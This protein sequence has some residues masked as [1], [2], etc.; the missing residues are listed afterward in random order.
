MNGTSIIKSG[1]V[2]QRPNANTAVLNTKHPS[3]KEKKLLKE[4]NK[5]ISPSTVEAPA[6]IIY[7][8]IT[9]RHHVLSGRQW[10]KIQIR[11]NAPC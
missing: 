4:I 7:Y 8:G 3:I 2:I 9:L 1:S 6:P 10:N 11:I 5:T